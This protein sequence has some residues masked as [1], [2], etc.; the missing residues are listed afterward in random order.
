M[1]HIAWLKT[2][3]VMKVF[4]SD[5]HYTYKQVYIWLALSVV[6]FALFVYFGMYGNISRQSTSQTL[7]SHLYWRIRMVHTKFS[8]YGLNSVLLKHLTLGLWQYLT[9]NKLK[10]SDWFKNPLCRQM[11]SQMIDLTTCT[12]FISSTVCVCVCVCVCG[13][14][15]R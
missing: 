7:N 5:I 6:S 12:Y 1:A 4:N 10:K 2:H 11:F 15:I 8:C 14:K 3:L 9:E 13:R